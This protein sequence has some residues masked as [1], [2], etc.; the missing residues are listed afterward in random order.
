MNRRSIILCTIL[1]VL[2]L[3]GIGWL[4]CSLFFSD[5]GEA[6]RTDRLAEGVEA[7]PSDAIFLLEA[8][9]LQEIKTMT[10]EGSTLGRLLGCIPSGA[11]EWEAVLSMHYSSKNAV[12]PLLV[13]TI[14]EDESAE[15]VMS[16]VLDE[17][18][19]V[20]DK[21]YGQV[22]VHKAAVPD[23]SFAVLGRF[24]I[25]S[26]SIV[27][28]E[29]SLRQLD[30]GIS[31]KDE[32][33]YSQIS[34]VTSDRGVLHVNFS[35]IGKLFSGAAS[36]G[37]VKYASAFSSFADW[38]AFGLSDGDSP[39]TYDGRVMSV[40]RGEK[41]SDVL[42]SQRGRRPDV[43]SVVPYNVPYV[44]TI[45]ITSSADYLRAYAAF[46][47][48]D[49]RRN[50]YEV[51]N[52]MVARD[53]SV[54]IAP[55]AFVESLKLSE[56]AV[57]A[58]DA[59]GGRKV[60]ALKCGNPGA[61][62]NIRDTVC[63]YRFK[64]CIPALLGS[65]FAPSSEE[66]CCLLGD[67]WILVGGQ[68]EMTSLRQ[69]WKAGTYFSLSDYL[70]QTP[71]SG[72]LREMSSLSLVI[73]AGRYSG[74]M[75]GYFKEPYANSV[76]KIFGE[77]NF[78]FIV[79][80]MH[81]VGDALGVRLSVYNEDLA[82]LPQPSRSVGGTSPALVEDLPVEIPEGPFPV[83]NFIDGSTNWL[84]QLEN[85][86]L[87]LLGASRNPVWTI[88]FATPLC[89]TVRQIDY[90]K[91][92]K[93]QM[94][95]GAGDKVWLLDRLGRKV[96]HFPIS[97]GKDILLGPDVYDFNGDRNYTMMVL[98]KDNTLMQYDIDGK[99]IPGWNTIALGEKIMALPEC[100]K[101]GN[102][103]YWAVR[104][105][106]QALLYDAHGTICA[107]FSRK[108]RLRKDTGFEPVSSHE[109]AVTTAEG[110]NM[111]LDLESGSFRKK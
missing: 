80:N 86:D 49:G 90:L 84:E 2:L 41:Y 68:E 92:N 54:G 79:L 97:L 57:F 75:P 76:G 62:G 11:S 101:I 106:Y 82:S 61:L 88:K 56:V 14:P 70:S 102:G 7:V 4:F 105:S 103:V 96:G 94:L 22:T 78:E 6:V 111:I 10:D 12:S 30:D 48:A 36:S 38:G 98:H 87:R 51:A 40:R 9:S 50:K 73:N 13:L 85:N 39:V 55:A 16:A 37:Y 18:G 52:A 15:S 65:L 100:I 66:S 1:A 60:L 17:C 74:V 81:K 47:A 34:G 31:V 59:D 108:Y 58:L 28:V 77:R 35:N 67:D 95:F 71:A 91:N 3:G 45:P 19:G 42:L 43:W 109:V 110:R 27:M 32:P 63:E 20:I 8:S 107:D 53:S 104:T 46:V 64:G 99:Q 44:M 33:L 25:A 72:E 89:G 24:L 93:L 23:A 26:P 69:S 21:R 29:A 83:K 5:G